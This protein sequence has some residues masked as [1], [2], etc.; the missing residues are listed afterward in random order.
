MSAPHIAAFPKCYIEAIVQ[1]R[2]ALLDWIDRSVELGAEGLELY[3][4]FL[5]DR[6]S[7]ALRAVRQRAEGHGLAIP[8]MCYSPDFT[9]PDASARQREVEEQKGMI[10]V[11]AELGGQF[12]RTL[13]G[14]RRREISENEGVDMVVSCIEQCL[15]EA[16]RCGVRLVIENHYKDGAWQFAEFAQR[17]DVFLRILARI[18]SPWLG[19]QYDPSNATVAGDDPLE[20]LRR[21]KH[22]VLTMHASDRYLAA[23][24][25]LD[26]LRA[27]EGKTGYADILKHGVTGKGLNDYPAIF[28]L[29]RDTRFAGWISIEDG[30]NGMDEMRESVEFLK[31]MRRRHYG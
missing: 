30:M 14:Q 25:T 4:R 9:Q 18:D 29:L 5:R 15:P 26:E 3:G 10:R 28:R 2:M 7:A 1:G 8:M 22:R 20:L 12:C 11:T 6:S 13:S 24:H 17:M 16:E 23:G 27:A 31:A 19:V 21:V